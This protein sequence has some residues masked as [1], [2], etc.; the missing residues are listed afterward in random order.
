LRQ[1]RRVEL[2]ADMSGLDQKNKTSA[3]AQQ[4]ANRPASE[5]PQEREVP[6]PAVVNALAERADL[7]A[8][9]E[10]LYGHV[11]DCIDFDT[12]FGLEQLLWHYVDKL[13][14]GELELDDG[15]SHWM[16]RRAIIRAA[17]DPS[18]SFSDVPFG[19]TKSEEKA[20]KFDADCPFCQYEA[21]HPR[22]QEKD[23][24]HDHDGDACPLCDDMAREWRE[25]HAD[26]LR[27]AGLR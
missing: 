3:A 21:E 15:L 23:G 9:E 16:I 6:S 24:E 1:A 27:R 17:H 12:L 19:I 22:E 25:K 8:L 20:A 14:L 10:Q 13:G 18:T 26:A 4:I 11:V 2:P 5:R 7:A